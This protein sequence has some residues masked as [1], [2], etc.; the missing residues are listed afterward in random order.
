MTHDETLNEF[1]PLADL[2]ETLDL[3]DADSTTG[4]DGTI[5]DRFTGRSQP[6]PHGRIFGGQVLA[7]SIIAAGR[8]VAC[9]REEEMNIHSHQVNYLHPGDPNIPLEFVVERLRESR[10]YSTRRVHILQ[11]GRPILAAMSSFA[12]PNDGFDHQ[13][14]APHVLGPEGLPS[15]SEDLYP[16]PATEPGNWVLRRAVEIR[17]VQ[18]HVAFSPASDPQETQQ[19]WFKTIGE[20]PD[21]SLLHAAILAY[22][23]DWVL[24]DPVLRRHGIAWFDPR[25]RVASLDQT[26]WFHRR[27]RADQWVMFN[28]SSP[29]AAHGRGLCLGHMYTAD[30]TLGVTA[31]QEGMVH[32]RD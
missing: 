29:T 11:N 14:E 16:M 23:S 22:A 21:D 27:M 24:L 15:L 8:S 7:Q 31:A 19:V 28:Q 20:L 4:T 3:H 6:T 26:M 25:L 17:H 10:S 18:G 13:I 1:D 9:S 2:L 12:R 32:I 5:R 30:G